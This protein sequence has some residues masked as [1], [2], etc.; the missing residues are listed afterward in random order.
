[1]VGKD[2]IMWGLIA[3]DEAWILF[4]VQWEITH[5]FQAEGWYTYP[6]C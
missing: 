1:M 2:Q 5:V 4:K 6:S 3:W